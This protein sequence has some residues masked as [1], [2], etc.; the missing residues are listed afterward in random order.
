MNN[1]DVRR[2]IRKANLLWSSPTVPRELNE[3]NKRKWIKAVQRL[4]DR[5]LLAKNVDRLESPR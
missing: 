5:W 2:L 4:G 1:L 3:L